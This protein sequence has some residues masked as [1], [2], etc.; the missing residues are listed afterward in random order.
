MLVSSINYVPDHAGIAI[1]STDFSEYLV[2]QGDQVSVVTGFPYYPQWKK[3]PEDLRSLFKNEKRKGVDIF[4][5]YLYV[6]SRVTTLKRF[7]HELTFS[8][9]AF[10]NFFKAGRKDVIVIFT[11]PVFLGVVGV[12]FKLIWHCPLVI[13]IQDLPF[14]AAI[15]LGLLKRG[16]PAWIIKKMETWV[17]QRSDLVVTISSAMF[18]NVMEKGVPESRLHLVPN[19][20][21]VDR[22]HDTLSAKGKFLA[23]H[24][25]A[26][27]KFTV[28]YAGNL[29]SKQGV[30][31]LLYLAR[32][33]RENTAFH[34][35][36]IGDGV[37]KDRLLNICRELK[38]ENLTFLPFMAQMEYEAMLVDIDVVY[39]AQRG[40]AGN[41]FFPS[42]LLGLMVYGKPMLVSADKDSELAQL[43]IESKCGLV[44]QYGD[45]DSLAENLTHFFNQR[46]VMLDMAKNGQQTVKFFSRKTVLADWYNHIKELS[47]RV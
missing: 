10:I 13:N 19:W 30:E 3:H 11:P 16:F 45:I 2:E 1:Y 31:N 7:L 44:S 27:G 28:V 47:V 17:Y 37:E 5:G 29:G 15:A 9:F 26:R 6:P 46:E 21:D 12:L 32:N 40:N 22:A 34:F 43:I 42:K 38:L 18:N 4:R 33:L 24:P 25:E 36:V 14:D 41:N 8:M 23:S 39:I 20:I 35:Y